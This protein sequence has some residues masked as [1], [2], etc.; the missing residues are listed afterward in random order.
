MLQN[1]FVGADSPELMDLPESDEALAARASVDEAA[2]T[3]L[4]RR[5]VDAVYRFCLIRLGNRHLAEDCTSEIFTTVVAALPRIRYDRFRGWLFNVARN[6]VATY[7][8]RHRAMLS[9]DTVG[10]MS[11]S[12]DIELLTEQAL[13]CEEIFRHVSKLTPDQQSV[14]A[15]RFAGLTGPEI[16][17]TLDRSGAW[18]HTTQY[19]AIRALR[20]VMQVNEPERAKQ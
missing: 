5:Y 3:E 2:F 8:R 19:R 6:E 16:G 15:L 12:E 17:E 13:T 20:S 11:S 18:V 7:Y 9:L 1:T 10:E 4:Y 14:I